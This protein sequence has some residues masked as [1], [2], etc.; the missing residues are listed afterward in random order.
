MPRKS[1]SPSSKSV[2]A[3]KS[4]VRHNRISEQTRT[5]CVKCDTNFNSWRLYRLHIC[6][7]YG[8]VHYECK[9][10]LST[11]DRYKMRAHGRYNCMATHHL[12]CEKCNIKFA[13][14]RLL[15]HHICKEG[16]IT[17]KCQCGFETKISTIMTVHFR[18]H[19]RRIANKSDELFSCKICDFKTRNEDSLTDHEMKHVVQQEPMQTYCEYCKMN[20]RLG[21]EFDRHVLRM[22]HI[23][24]VVLSLE[25]DAT[26]LAFT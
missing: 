20:Y 8:N 21:C 25:S 10:G 26:G 15:K 24:N 23:V 7:E 9:C 22:S 1:A 13:S 3:S 11:V 19:D 16:D 5:K 2:S 6:D 14:T 12:K 4:V 18:N 17:F